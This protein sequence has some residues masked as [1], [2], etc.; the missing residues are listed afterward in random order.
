MKKTMVL[1]AC[2]SAGLI[3]SNTLFAHTQNSENSTVAIIESGKLMGSN[4]D[5]VTTFYDVPYAQNPLRQIADFKLRKHT[6]L[7]VE[8]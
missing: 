8:Y 3:Q 1:V 2:L 5:G 4:H 6:K 7:G